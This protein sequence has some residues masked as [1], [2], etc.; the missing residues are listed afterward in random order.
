MVVCIVLGEECAVTKGEVRA[1]MV[2]GAVRLLAEKGVEGTSFA[3]V[4]T[5]VGAPRGS[6]YHH[7]PGGKAE[8]VGAALDLAGDRALAVMEPIQG[9]PAPA[10]VRRFLS[11]WRQLLEATELRAGCAVLAVTVAADDARLLAH[12]GR[13]F[14]AWREQLAGLLADGGLRRRQAE[15]LAALTIAA[16]EGAVALTRA[17][18]DWEPFDLVEAY[19]IT[20]AE[21]AV[22]RRR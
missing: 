2:G 13:V 20:E 16:S 11:L 7:F 22:R 21:R 15:S 14:R 18:G 10:V 5:A 17:E 6:T 12:A 4:L 19:L 9:Q 1:R 8:L 3:E